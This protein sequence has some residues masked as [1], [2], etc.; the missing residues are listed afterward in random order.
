MKNYHENSYLTTNKS[1]PD[2]TDSI[3]KVIYDWILSLNILGEKK[4]KIDDLPIN[5]DNGIV[6]CDLINRME[7]VNN[8]YIQREEV[9]KGIHRK[10][11]NKSQKLVNINKVLDFLRKNEKVN[12]R[13]LWET[14]QI[15]L[16]DNKVIWELLHDIWS[17][18]NTK[19]KLTDNKIKKS[20]SSSNLKKPINCILKEEEIR[21]P[22]I[23]IVPLKQ[24][25][26]GYNNY[27]YDQEEEPTNDIVQTTKYSENYYKVN[28]DKLFNK[29]S[30]IQN[31]Q[32]ALYNNISLNVAKHSKTKSI[33]LFLYLLQVILQ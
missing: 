31:Y 1:K 5:F 29:Y 27:N 20:N 7:G 12:P 22:D 13:H 10:I 15:A 30:D 19:I 18:Y 2:L 33:K 9:L 23:N 8:T 3:M 21:K 25:N 6:L 4:F 24:D 26:F 11:L 32:N 28:K 16:G 14:N 17:I